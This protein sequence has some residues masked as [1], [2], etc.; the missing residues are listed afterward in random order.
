MPAHIHKLTSNLGNIHFTIQ[1][2]LRNTD[3]AAIKPILI[4]SF[5]LIQSCLEIIDQLPD[6]SQLHGHYHIATYWTIPLH[7]AK[8]AEAHGFQCVEYYKQAN[9]MI[10]LVRAYQMISYH[11]VAHGEPEKGLKYAEISMDTASQTSNLHGMLW[12][13]F[14]LGVA[15]HHL[16][17]Y[18]HALKAYQRACA[19]GDMYIEL[20]ALVAQAWCHIEL[21]NLYHSSA[22]LV[23]ATALIHTSGLDPS[24]MCNA[25]ISL[26]RA[27]LHF[28]RTEFSEASEI[29]V[30]LPPNLP[31]PLGYFTSTIMLKDYKQVQ[32]HCHRGLEL[33]SV[34]SLMWRYRVVCLH[35][36]GDVAMMQGSPSTA[37]Q[38]FIVI[39]A[40]SALKSKAIDQLDALRKLGDIY[41]YRD[42]NE[43]TALSVFEMVLEG[44][45]ARSIH[46]SQGDCMIRLAEILSRQGA[47]IQAKGYLV[48]AIPL[49]E[50]SLQQD[51]VHLCQDRIA[52]LELL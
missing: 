8:H 31:I 26:T 17:Q 15:W 40:Y 16:D 38:Y 23:E 52:L 27:H 7:E 44:Y 20:Q 12:G 46:S 47:V 33:K 37:E 48:K 29:Q 28:K 4:G 50:R 3:L 45:T 1:T 13:Y 24:S 51:Q 5:D 21:G 39:L 18:K 11:Y 10:G 19:L 9:D 25:K 22:L 36:L 42:G 35:L 30:T 2:A 34:M 6:N 49:F 43:T 14:R 32:A 41:L